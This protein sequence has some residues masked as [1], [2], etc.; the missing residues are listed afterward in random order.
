[1]SE[2]TNRQERALVLSPSKIAFL[3]FGEAAQAF[4]LGLSQEG[5][6]ADLAAYDIKTDGPDAQVK[7]DE[8]TRSNVTGTASCA[9]LC[10]RADVIFSLVTADQAEVAANNVA[11]ADLNGALY[12]DC[13]SCAPE[14]KRQAAHVIEAA[15]GR[16]VDVAIMTPVHPKLHRSPCFLAGPHAQAAHE[17]TQQLGMDTKIVGDQVGEASTRKMI[18]SVMIKGMEALTLECFLAARKAGIEA[19]ILAS[20]TAS[21]ADF[22]WSKRAPYM[23]ERAATHGIRRAAEMEQVVKTLSDLGLSTHMTDGTVKRQ[24]EIGALGLSIDAKD[25]EDLGKISDI[26]LDGLAQSSDETRREE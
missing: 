4:A 5:A 2:G 1:M 25:A 20:L 19:E 16:Y 21:F 15:N 23:M 10:E 18:R 11:A 14:T 17:V 24:R 22:D 7:R 13:N 12:L 9:E 8:Y 6:G 3:G 26:L